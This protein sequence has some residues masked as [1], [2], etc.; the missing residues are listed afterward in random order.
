MKKHFVDQHASPITAGLETPS[1]HNSSM[2]FK[3]KYLKKG[4]EI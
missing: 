4:I 1:F 2:E 3:L